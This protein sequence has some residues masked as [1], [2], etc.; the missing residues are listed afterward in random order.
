MDWG[1]II[2]GALGGGAQAAQGMAQNAIE[3]QNKLDAAKVVSD[4]EEAKTQRAAQFQSNL[5]RE[6]AQKE[7]DRVTGV[8]GGATGQSAVDRLLQSGDIEKAD[9]LAKAQK[10]GISDVPYGGVQL[11]P[12]GKVRYDNS[13]G[14][15]QADM[16]RAQAAAERAKH[17]GGHDMPEA[18]RIQL[19]SLEK[20]EEDARQKLR[21]MQSSGT[22]QPTDPG[23]QALTQEI[24][25]IQM[26]KLRVQSQHGLIKGDED[27]DALLART[28]DPNIIKKALGQAQAIGGRYGNAF[29]ASVEK[30]GKLNTPDVANDVA[31]KPNVVNMPT[32][33]KPEEPLKDWVG[34]GFTWKGKHFDS[35]EEAYAAAGM[36]APTGILDRLRKRL[37][38]PASKGPVGR[39]FSK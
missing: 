28:S 14:K 5:A 3:Q 21:T 11:G 8:L 9:A 20:A 10:A 23:A 16:L 24:S 38:E 4:L 33:A 22:F 29:A 15:Q 31:N 1:G 18:A 39:G 17:P 35:A 32:D 12:D 26:Q 27:A 7:R 19:Q 25:G 13:V 30:S 36:P 6:N 34:T 37:S 2:A